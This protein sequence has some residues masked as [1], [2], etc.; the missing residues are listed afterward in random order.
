VGGRKC[1]G[2]NELGMNWLVG[3][4]RKKNR[5]RRSFLQLRGGVEGLVKSMTTREEEAQQEEIGAGVYLYTRTHTQ[6][7]RV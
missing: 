6:H 3:E 4:E 1:V 7:H 5:R 2:W